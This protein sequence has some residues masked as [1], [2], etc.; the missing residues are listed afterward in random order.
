MNIQDYITIDPNRR[1]GK[2]TLIG[3][4]ITVSDILNWLGNGMTKKEI[5]ADY[6]EL[7]EA[8]IRA[9]L[10]YAATRQQHLGFAS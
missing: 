2:P 7:S 4:R 3:T 1:F 6:P 9:A 10:I 8:M 5:L